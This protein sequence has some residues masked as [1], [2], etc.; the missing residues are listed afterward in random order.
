MTSR[1]GFT[2]F[3]VVVALALS[4][5]LLAGVYAAMDLYWRFSTTGQEE[6][7][8]AQIA[9]AVLR[10]IETDLRSVVYQSPEMT[11]AAK[12]AVPAGGTAASGGAA[13]TSRTGSGGSTGGGTSTGAAGSM[14]GSSSGRSGS[15]GT[16]GGMGGGSAGGASS[17]R[18]GAGGSSGGGGGTPAG[19][20]GG[21]A[22]GGS[23]GASGGSGSGGTSG[24]T[25]TGGSSGGGGTASGGMGS[26]GTASGGTGTGQVAGGGAPVSGLFGTFDSLR[27]TA[28]APSR[29]AVYVPLGQQIPGRARTSDLLTVGYQLG[30][31]NQTMTA[32]PSGLARMEGDRMLLDLAQQ[33]GDTQTQ[34]ASLQMLAPEVSSL[35]FA[36]YDGYQW[37]SD[38]D[39]STFGGLPMAV[40]VLVDITT[41]PRVFRP[42]FA[43]STRQPTTQ[44][45]R[46]VVA[47]PLAKAIDTSTL[48]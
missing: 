26:G 35:T 8:R 44:T 20:S 15:T 2:L 22:S 9:R 31:A 12:A 23:R 21:T 7:E 5:L 3:E 1:R 10:R 25:S 11:E 33:N 40:E 43:A 13:S 47:L 32:Q 16:T 37:R 42:G 17:G 14:G 30:D 19:S 34:M 45:F 24:G 38:W 36:Y 48:E 27:L 28:A 41:P 18:T 4:V 6:V 39:S 29:R 46:L